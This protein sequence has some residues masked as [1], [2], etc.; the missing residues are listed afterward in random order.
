[1]ILEDGF[2]YDQLVRS[3]YLHPTCLYGYIA[4]CAVY[5]MVFDTSCEGFS[6][7]FL[8]AGTKALIPG[9][10]DEEKAASIL[11]AQQDVMEAISFIL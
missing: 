11:N 9:I 6:Y 7:D 5:S 4:A 8:D 1:M 3:D 2:K 10:T